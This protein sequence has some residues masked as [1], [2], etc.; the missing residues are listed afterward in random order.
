MEARFEE[1]IPGSTATYDIRPE[2]IYYIYRWGGTGAYH[3]SGFGE[4]QYQAVA[5]RVAEQLRLGQLQEGTISLR[6]HWKAEYGE[7]VRAYLAAAA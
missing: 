2:D 7:L 6:P 1:A 5:E 4:D 3:V